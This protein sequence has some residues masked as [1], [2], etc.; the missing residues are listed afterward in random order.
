MT[1]DTSALRVESRA[2]LAFGVGRY[3][4]AV[5]YSA[6]RRYLGDVGSIP[7]AAWGTLDGIS[8]KLNRDW[9]TALA[10]RL[11]E[12]KSV[13]DETSRMADGIIQVAADYEGTD[14][15]V[16]TT[17]AL[18]NRDLSPYLP[19]GDGYG[20]TVRARPGGV[21]VLAGPPERRLPDDQPVVRIPPDNDR[22]LAIRSETLP[23]IRE[24][25]EPITIGSTDGNDLWFSGGHTTYYENG[26]GDQLDTFIHEYRDMLLQLEA[27]LIE[28]GTGERLPLTDLMIHAWRSAPGII[29][30]RADLV[31]SAA[32]TYAEL[33][34]RM[35]GDLAS[36]NHYWE[37]AAAQALDEY[38]GR[39]STYLSQIEAQARWLADEGKKAAT[40]LEGLRNAY[41]SLGYQHIDTLINALKTYID[42]VNGLFA[43]CS[44]PEKALLDTVHTFVYYLLDA[45]RL[46]VEAISDLIRID[47]QERKERPDLGTRGHDSTPFPDITVGVDAWADRRGWGPRADLPAA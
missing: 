21:G 39:V 34:A 11:A 20:T 32:N 36:L 30:N 2:L 17:F 4:D 43:S 25:E 41:A 7:S 1:T 10:G 46:H 22:L 3:R 23:R 33:N 14:L 6:V 44:N 9:G 13:G 38:A 15:A 28:L 45:E 12:A 24:V 29:H 18:V 47:E 26:A 19:L 31:H 27:V 16:A 5:V 37:G 35:G 40:M 8:G 42:A